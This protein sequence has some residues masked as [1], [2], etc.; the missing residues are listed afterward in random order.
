[1]CI[2]PHFWPY[3]IV[4]DYLGYLSANN[5]SNFYNI[6]GFSDEEGDAENGQELVDDNDEEDG[7][8]VDEDDN[9]KDEGFSEEVD[10]DADEDDEVKMSWI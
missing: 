7:K 5:S 1:M 10:E 8:D 3:S 6:L 9:D 2:W 4:L